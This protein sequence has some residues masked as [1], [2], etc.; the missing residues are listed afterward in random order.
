MCRY[1]AMAYLRVSV[2]CVNALASA[3]IGGVMGWFGAAELGASA[4]LLSFA[5]LAGFSTVSGQVDWVYQHSY[6][7]WRRFALLLVLVLMAAVLG[8]FG[9]EVVAWLR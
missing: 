6:T 1:L 2:V 4:A 8:W 7:Q 9:Y 5:F 3:A